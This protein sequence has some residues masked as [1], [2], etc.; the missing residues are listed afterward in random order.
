M[1]AYLTGHVGECNVGEEYV[2]KFRKETRKDPEEFFHNV[3]QEP[4]EYGCCR[5]ATIWEN[6]AWFND[7]MGN[8]WRVDDTNVKKQLAAY[9]REWIDYNT[10]WIKQKK[11]ML[12]GLQAGKKIE[13]WTIAAA[14]REIKQHQDQIAE[15]KRLKRIT[16]S[17]AYMSVGIWFQDSISRAQTEFMMR[18][19][20]KFCTIYKS[21]D[22]KK[23]HIEGYRIME[24]SEKDSYS[25]VSKGLIHQ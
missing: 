25:S 10:P 23:L 13:N 16:R 8:E 22:G 15:A 6:P 5:P 24:R 21:T 2:S 11:A 3:I 9:V 17:P 7:G 1:C 14:K 18:R 12:K 20:E 19:A 4:D